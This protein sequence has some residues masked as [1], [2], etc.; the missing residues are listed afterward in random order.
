[1]TIRERQ[2]REAHDREN[3]WRPMNTAPR[4]T[5]LICDLLFDDMVGHFA[6]EGLQFFCDANGHWYQI[7][8]PKRVFRPINWRPSYVRMTIERR[9]LI[10]SRAR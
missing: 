6:A 9:N 10:K 3:P 1:M 2:E 5:G 8:S 4:G 7:D